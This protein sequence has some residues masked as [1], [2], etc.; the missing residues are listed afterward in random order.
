M[1]RLLT[2]STAT[3]SVLLLSASLSAFASDQLPVAALTASTLQST[4]NAI[5]A[6]NP[7]LSKNAVEYA[8]KGYLYAQQKHQVGNPNYLTIVNFDE[9]S[10]MDRL[11]VIDLRTDK[12]VLSAHVAQGSGSGNGD[13]ATHF[14]NVQG[15]NATSLGAYVTGETYSGEHGRSEH[16]IGLEPG[17]ND[18]AVTRDIEIHKASY[19]NSDGAGHSWGCFAVSDQKINQFINLVQGGSVIFAYATPEQQDPNLA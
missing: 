16:V 4:E 13:I 10:T 9:P 2:A 1:R 5:L 11:H 3:L 17:I 14:S 18:N 12:V 15:S 19:V 8:L 7:E 6:N